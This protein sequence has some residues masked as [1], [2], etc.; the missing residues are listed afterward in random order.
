MIAHNLPE[1]SV[2]E[3]KMKISC[4]AAEQTEFNQFINTN[5]NTINRLLKKM[6]DKYYSEFAEIAPAPEPAIKPTLH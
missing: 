4:L 1:D 2:E 5:Q 3:M 6:R